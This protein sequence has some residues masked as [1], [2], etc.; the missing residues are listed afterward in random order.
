M[1]QPAMGRPKTARRRKPKTVGLR[2]PSDV[3]LRV[4]PDDFWRLCMENRDLRL[5]RTAR[6]RLIA[7]APAGS[8]TSMRNAYLTYRLV[9]W[10]ELDG[11]GVFFDS[12]GGFTFPSGLTCAPDASWIVR[13]RWEALTSEQQEKFAPI[14]PDF[15]AALTSRTD[16][17]R[18][19]QKKMA[20]YVSQG[21]RLGWLIDPK[22]CEVDI[23][24]PGRVVET[25]KR[26]A[27]LSGEDVLPGFVLDLKG[28]LFD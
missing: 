9:G 24:R 12:S 14:C 11:T 26:P 1:S 10:A 16:T 22:S 19:L 4:T 2:V 5:E 13:E 17:R 6:G 8:G 21:I 18:K 15:V 7:M 23:Y 3:R 20:A 27:T 25:L 28:I